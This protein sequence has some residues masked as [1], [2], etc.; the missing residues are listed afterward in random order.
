MHDV[1]YAIILAIV[2]GLTEFLPVSSTGHLVLVSNL[3]KLPQTEFLKSFEIIIQLG[4]IL[5]IVNMYRTTLL[6]SIAV[7]TRI[8]IAFV[9]TA[10]VGFF[11]YDYIKGVLLGNTLITLQAL[12]LGGIV[13]ILV[14]RFYKE[15]KKHTVSTI[16]KISYPAALVIGVFQSLSVVPGVS[17]AAA[18]ILGGI[19]M[20]ANR[21]TAVEFSFLLAIPTMIAASGY[22]LVKT[23]FSFSAY[24]WI[25]LTIGFTGAFIVAHFAVKIFITYVEKHSFTAFGIY[26]IILAAVYWFLLLR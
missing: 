4:A 20:R 11:F 19:F 8:L 22:D 6:K 1:V 18:S 7:W 21:K 14:D 12:F 10:I 5:A 23:N 24:E 17:R 9:P 16:D 25:L 26:R 13:L 2:E 3:L 15:E